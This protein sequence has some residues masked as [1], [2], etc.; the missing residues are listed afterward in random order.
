MLY[1]GVRYCTGRYAEGKQH[2]DSYISLGPNLK[3][4]I[5]NIVQIKPHCGPA[6]VVLVVTPFEVRLPDFLKTSLVNVIH[7]KEIVKTNDVVAIKP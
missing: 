2:D 6:T 1:E 3:A 4:R 7:V 5:D